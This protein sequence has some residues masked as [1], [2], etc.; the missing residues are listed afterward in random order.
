MIR[1]TNKRILEIV[2]PSIIKT[3]RRHE[4]Y[5]SG[6]QVVHVF[7]LYFNHNANWLGTKL[8]MCGSIARLYACLSEHLNV[9][10]D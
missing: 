3:A 4:P 5:R 1:Y 6:L 10:V 2:N 8:P 9:K 7:T